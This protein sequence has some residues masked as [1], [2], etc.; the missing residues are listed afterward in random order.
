MLTRMPWVLVLLAL[1]AYHGAVALEAIGNSN[2]KTAAGLWVANRTAA[3]AKYGV[4]SEWDVS[5]VT[6]LRS[7]K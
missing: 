6:R 3:I 4:I 5:A 2:I 1:H 7:S